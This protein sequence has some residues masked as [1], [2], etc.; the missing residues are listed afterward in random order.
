L[1]APG[2]DILKADGGCSIGHGD[3]PWVT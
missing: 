1:L 3:P 2:V